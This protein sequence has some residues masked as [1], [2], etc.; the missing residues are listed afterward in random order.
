MSKDDRLKALIKRRLERCAHLRKINAR[1][2]IIKHEQIMLLR[3]RRGYLKLG[4]ADGT[5]DLYNRHVTARMGH[6]G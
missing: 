1:Q 2:W 5:M 6:D 3:H 4:I